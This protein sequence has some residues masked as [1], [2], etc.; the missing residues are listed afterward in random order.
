MI[1]GLVGNF[2]AK[3]SPA[4]PHEVCFMTS[5]QLDRGRFSARL[6]S[7]SE[8][9]T[10]RRVYVRACEI[11]AIDQ[12]CCSFVRLRVHLLTRLWVAFAA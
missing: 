5:R 2:L 6:A 1:F 11:R 3:P 12:I 8:V 4:L 9:V 10:R 7:T